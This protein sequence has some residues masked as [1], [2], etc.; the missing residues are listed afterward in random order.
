MGRGDPYN[1]EIHWSNK[2]SEIFRGWA[3][4]IESTGL[5]IKMNGSHSLANWFISDPFIFTIVIK[6]L[7]PPYHNSTLWHS[8]SNPI[9]DLGE[10]KEKKWW[11]FWNVILYIYI[12]FKKKNNEMQRR[13]RTFISLNLSKNEI[14]INIGKAS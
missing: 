12:F 10:K 9:L 1:P 11:D 3:T 5:S 2:E 6:R 7:Y 4:Q 8:V 14:D 13:E